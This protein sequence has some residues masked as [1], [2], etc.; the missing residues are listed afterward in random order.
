M[1]FASAVANQ[2]DLLAFYAATATII[3]VLYLAIVFQVRWADWDWLG[4][5]WRFWLSIGITIE[6]FV[7]ESAALTG[8][9]AGQD[10]GRKNT[11][12]QALFILGGCLMIAGPLSAIER[13][14]EDRRRKYRFWLIVATVVVV[15]VFYHEI[16]LNSDAQLAK[17]E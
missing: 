3:P 5:R 12:A 2:T 4:P 14:P 10:I 6:V 9:I 13:L 16:A 11:I 7:A 17:G 1:P 15:A 8:M